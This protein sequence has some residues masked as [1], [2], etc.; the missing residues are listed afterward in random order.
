MHATATPAASP[1]PRPSLDGARVLL[2]DDQPII[3]EAVRRMLADEDGIEF[4]YCQHPGEAID[5][6]VAVG[7]T[8]ML[9]DLV[10]PEIDG[11]ELVRRF[12]ADP[13][14]RELPIIVL[15]TKEEP[16]IK[17]EAFTLGANDYIVKLPDRLELIA[18]TRYHSRGF[19][20]LQE[21][22]EAFAALEASRQKLA[23]DLETAAGYV[24]SLIPAPQEL[25]GL[26][27]DWRFIPSADLGGD[28]FGYH[29]LDDT[30]TAIYLLDVCGHGVG[31]AL[32]SVSA[33][34][35][36]RSGSLAQTDFHDPGSVLEALNRAFPMEQQNDMF[37]TIWYGVFDASSRELRWAGGGHPAAVLI[38]EGL[39][40][41]RMLESDGPLIGVVEGLSYGSERLV[42]PAAARLFIYSDGAFEIGRHD[43]TMWKFAEFLDSLVAPA[44]GPENRMDRLI[45]EIRSISGRDDMNDDFSMIELAF[46]D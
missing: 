40:N 35:A 17:A 12:R 5:T 14:F 19:V 23:D 45:G 7:P 13:R 4:H 33:L 27:A 8:V 46:R 15:S 20:A 21:R 31:A 38:G 22:N 28:A 39:E 26:Q 18:R 42:V 44:Q 24:R 34:N 16:A 10:M 30:C 9:L 2:I 3:G 11:L 1:A 36:L 6:A 29:A 41:P 37:F 25:V 32:L 43:G